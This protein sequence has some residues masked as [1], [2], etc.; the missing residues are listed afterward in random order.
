VPWPARAPRTMFVR[1][2]PAASRLRHY[3]RSAKCPSHDRPVQNGRGGF[4]GESPESPCFP[5]DGQLN[6]AIG[7]PSF[8][9]FR[10]K[11]PRQIPST[12]LVSLLLQN[13]PPSIEVNLSRVRFLLLEKFGR[14][15]PSVNPGRVFRPLFPFPFRLSVP[16]LK[17]SISHTAPAMAGWLGLTLSAHTIRSLPATHSFGN[18]FSKWREM[19]S[20]RPGPRQE[21]SVLLPH[22]GN[23]A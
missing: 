2:W 16:T 5:Q 18:A 17:H 15:F 21:R 19:D 13:D 10:A 6:R 23:N 3:C 14:A 9:S 11:K 20:V 8:S 1:R 4:E 12:G 22:T 7:G